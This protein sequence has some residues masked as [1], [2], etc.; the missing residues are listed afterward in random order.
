MVGNVYDELDFI[1]IPFSEQRLRFKTLPKG[2]GK[3]WGSS[4]HPLALEAR[5]ALQ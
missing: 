2:S 4:R 1:T 3:M 5:E